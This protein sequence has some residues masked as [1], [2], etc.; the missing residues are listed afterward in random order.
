ME[1]IHDMFALRQ[2]WIGNLAGKSFSERVFEEHTGLH[3]YITW[4]FRILL[5]QSILSN[6][7]GI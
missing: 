1:N 2:D 6:V 7:Q 3:D 4:H 5:I